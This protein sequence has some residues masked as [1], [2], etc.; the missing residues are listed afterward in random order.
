MGCSI[1]GCVRWNRCPS[2]TAEIAKSVHD[3][4]GLVL[5][6]SDLL[7]LTVLQPPSSFGADVG[8]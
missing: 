3:N 1:H 2:L 8:A 5:V 4:G 6:A 7:A